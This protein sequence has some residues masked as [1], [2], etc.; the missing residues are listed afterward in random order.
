MINSEENKI[1]IWKQILVFDE[2]LVLHQSAMKDNKL[3]G[4]PVHKSIPNG[5]EKYTQMIENVLS[6]KINNF[7]ATLIL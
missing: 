3:K 6:V 2:N 1:I 5:A 7:P 4:L